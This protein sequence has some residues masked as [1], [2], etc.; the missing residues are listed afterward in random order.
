MA[1]GMLAGLGAAPALADHHANGTHA[2]MH[3]SHMAL[4]SVLESDVRAQDAARDQYR[5]PFETLTFFG[6][7]PGMSVVDYMPA[8]GWYT[9]VLVPYLGAEGRYIGLTP[10]P[11]AA[12]GERFS[13]YFAG[14][15]DA[16]TKASPGW[17]LSGAPMTIHHS[18]DVPESM[19]GTVDRVL[20]FREMHNLLRSGALYTELT[21][22]RSMLKDDG[23]LGIVQH[24]AKEDAPGDYTLGNA[25]YLR[26]SDVIAMVEAHG[27]RLV[28]MSDVNANPADPADWEGGVWTLPPGN[29]G[30]D[31]RAAATGESDRM[32]LLFAKR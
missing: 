14:L 3:A 18:G 27:F 23:R 25:G 7:E 13:G 16:F 31:P 17:G 2:E 28:G 15:P 8:S 11:D 21:R 20:I 22:I 6:V 19:A 30:D 32:T 1:A 4:R 24:R 26:Q 9:R 10:D 12:D 5:H 29:R